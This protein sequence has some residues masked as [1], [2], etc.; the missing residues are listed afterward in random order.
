MVITMFPK[1]YHVFVANDLS[2][3][4]PYPSVLFSVGGWEERERE[5]NNETRS[6]FKSELNLHK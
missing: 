4:F 5:S 2:D 3:E 6:K 1:L